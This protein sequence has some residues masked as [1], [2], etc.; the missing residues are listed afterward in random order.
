MTKHAKLGASGATRWRNCA[1]SIN[2][3]EGLP[4]ITS[5]Y[6]AEGTVAHAIAEGVLRED[7]WPSL[8]A[9]ISEDGYDIEATQE[10]FDAIQVYIDFVNTQAEGRTLLIEQQFDLAPLS[11]PGPMY[12]TADAVIW[13]EQAKRL[14]VIDYKHG[15]GVSVDAIDNDQGL[16]YMLGAVVAFGRRPNALTFTIVQPRAPHDAG[17]IRSWDVKWDEVI[18]AKQ[19]L[20]ADAGATLD[21]DAPLNAGDWC[22]FCKA[23]AIC[24]AQKAQVE[25]LAVEAFAA[26]PTFPEAAGLSLTDIAE[27]LAKAP[28][29]TD[30]IK[31]V[32]SYALNMLERGETVPG[33]KLV[34]KRSNRKWIDEREALTYLKNRRLKSGERSTIKVITPAQAEKI[35]KAGGGPELPKRLWVKP[36]GGAALA[37]LKDKRPEKVPSVFETFGAITET[38]SER[39]D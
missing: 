23:K 27:V 15:S 4:D 36:E 32:Q 28:A 17:I 11:P 1:G 39:E 26:E 6:A 35:L 33:Y 34:E 19:S 7:G 5:V 38:T 12:G 31:S 13:D 2:L 29:V 30:W 18:F 9:V 10:M 24:P 22:R 25:A 20:F 14:H 8:G 16:V 37:P 3:C 21:P